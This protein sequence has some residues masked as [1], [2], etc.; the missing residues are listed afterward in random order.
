MVATL[1]KLVGI[2]PAV[3]YN[4]AIPSWFAMTAMGAFSVTFN[5]VKGGA[6]TSSRLRVRPYLFGLA[7]ALFVAV[8]GNLG[9]AYLL[10]SRLGDGVL[11]GF[12]STIPGLVPLVRAVAGFLESVFGGR[13]L[14]VGLDEWYW[15]ASRAI[16][17]GPYEAVITEFPFFTFLYGDLHAHLIAMPLTFLSLAAAL[18][19]VN[20]QAGCRC[21][22]RED[23]TWVTGRVVQPAA[24]DA[25]VANHRRHA[26]L[27]YLGR[28][29]TPVD[30][31]RRAG[32]RR[33]L[34]PGLLEL[35][36]G[37]ES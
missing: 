26:H 2:V 11:E 13:T 30:R 14:P 3:A 19:V 35:A 20:A 16:P 6:G 27:Q 4:L 5:L 34:A 21:P 22:R 8:L 29:S 23:S 17:A 32:H 24:A 10:F 7:G 31:A 28:S 37:L 12:R 1:V 25:L 33:V 15:N 36:P 18:A 9:E